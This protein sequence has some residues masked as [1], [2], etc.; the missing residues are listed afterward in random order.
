MA[1]TFQHTEK[2]KFQFKRSNEAYPTTGINGGP[3]GAIFKLDQVPNIVNISIGSKWE[4][5]AAA[6]EREP[7]IL[8][9]DPIL[10]GFHNRKMFMWNIRIPNRV[11]T[12]RP[13]ER[14]FIT[15]RCWNSAF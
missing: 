7:V 8:K 2:G 4:H 5:G 14:R 13:P 15:K 9:P 3:N 12:F 11:T 10:T 1:K 6:G